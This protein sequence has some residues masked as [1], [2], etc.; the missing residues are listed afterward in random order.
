MRRWREAVAFF[1]IYK[2]L[3]AKSINDKWKST[4]RRKHFEKWRIYS[5]KMMWKLRPYRLEIRISGYQDIRISEDV[6]PVIPVRQK[7]SVFL[8]ML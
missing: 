2:K 4:Y 5:K 7:E 6:L 3:Y 8:M 1:Y